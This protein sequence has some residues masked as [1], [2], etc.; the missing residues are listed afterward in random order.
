MSVHTPTVR[1][2]PPA[3]SPAV[4]E[5]EQRALSEIDAVLETL[6]SPTQTPNP[7]PPNLGPAAENVDLENPMAIEQ[8]APDIV[9]LA[10]PF[11]EIEEIEP[12]PDPPDAFQSGH[13][14]GKSS[15][16]PIKQTDAFTLSPHLV[17]RQVQPEFEVIIT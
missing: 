6:V 3:S 14:N 15:N 10:E 16:Q 11:H 2:E 13:G 1:I 8:K 12:L 5:T 4:F 17:G 9:A 7:S